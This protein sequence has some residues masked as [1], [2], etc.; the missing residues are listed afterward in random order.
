MSVPESIKYALGLIWNADYKTLFVTFYKECTEKIFVSFFAVYLIKY[1]FECI[2]KNVEFYNL[3]KVILGFCGVHVIIHINSAY[4]DYRNRKMQ[5]SIYQ[6]VFRMVVEKAEKIQLAQYEL[7][8]FYNRFSRALDECLDGFMDGMC[9]MALSVGWGLAFA[10]SLVIMGQVD[11]K[12]PVLTVVTSVGTFFL[13]VKMNEAQMRLREA[14][15]PERRVFDY[16]KRVVYEKKYA[17]ELRLYPIKKTLFARFRASNER[18]YKLQKKYYLKIGLCNIAEIAG[19]MDIAYF[20]TL[21]YVNYIV[22][23]GDNSMFGAYVAMAGSMA[24][25]SHCLRSCINNFNEAGKQFGY[26]CNLREFLEY[27]PEQRAKGEKMPEEAL[28]DIE[29]DQ[30]SFVYTGSSKPVIDKLSLQI[31]KGEK[32]ALVGENGAGKTTLMKLIMGLYP[33]TS[34]SIR[35]N[36]TAIEEYEEQSY[37][38]RFGTVFQDFQI[39]ALPLCENVLMRQP[40]SEEE[41]NLVMESLVKAQFGDVLEKLPKGINTVLT[42]EFDENGFV[43]S[44]GQAQKVAIARVFAKNPDIVI[45]DEPSSALDPIAEYKM[46]ENMLEASYGKTVF[47][48]SHRMSSARIADRIFYLEHGKIVEQGTHDELMKLDG[49]Y[50]KM[51]TLQA[52]NYRDKTGGAEDGE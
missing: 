19:F 36:G 43:C 17:G 37:R 33:V 44:G 25:V 5:P 14:E 11:L 48:I 22:K 9:K 38:E 29:L 28:G 2:E 4:M 1:I 50:A 8:D 10:C 26:M 46:Y 41:R 39:F 16:T 27:E 30:V 12:L 15:T 6:Y 23:T 21:F 35:I 13:S 49:K 24:F 45:L 3:V 31:H 7:P 20:G 40:K 51:F 32:I 47:F 42:K 52:S 18:R 34:G